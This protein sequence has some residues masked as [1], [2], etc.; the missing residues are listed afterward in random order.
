MTTRSIVKETISLTC[1]IL[2]ETQVKSNLWRTE[3]ADNT[4][5]GAQP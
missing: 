3:I 4:L 2:R 5:E 1:L